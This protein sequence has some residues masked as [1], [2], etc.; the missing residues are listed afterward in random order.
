MKYLVLSDVHANLYALQA[1]L[2]DVK[3]FDQ[4]IFLGDLANFGPHPGECVDLLREYSPI[5][6]MGNHDKKIAYKD[7]KEIFGMNGQEQN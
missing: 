4:I 1:V 3:Q 2:A 6:I 7:E 5:C